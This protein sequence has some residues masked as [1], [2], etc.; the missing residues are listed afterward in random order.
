MVERGGFAKL[1]PRPVEAVTYLQLGGDGKESEIVIED[2][3][4][5]RIWK[6]LHLLIESYQRRQTGYTSRRAVF[7]AGREGDYDHLARFGEWQMSDMPS[8]QDVG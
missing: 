3:V 2:D 6:Q 5:A 7:E 1:G 8:R 4:L